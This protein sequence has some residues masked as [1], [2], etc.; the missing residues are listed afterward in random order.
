MY[1]LG[2]EHR[3]PEQELDLRGYRDSRPVRIGN[4]AV[5][6]FQLDIYGELMDSAHLYRRLGNE[7]D[8]EYWELLRGVVEFVIEHWREPDDGIWESR[9]ER[10]H[11]VFS[12]AMAWVA[13]D[14]AIQAVEETDLPGDLER[15]RTVRDAIRA[16]VLDHGYNAER[17]AFTQHYGGN[18]LD[19]SVLMLPLFRFIEATD[20]RMRST[21]DA[22]R[23]DLTSHQGFVYRYRDFDDGV[24]GTEGT[25]AICTFWLCNNLIQVGEVEEATELFRRAC[26]TAN[27]LGLMSEE[28]DPEDGMLGNFPQAFSHLALINVAVQLRRAAEANEENEAADEERNAAAGGPA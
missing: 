2:G 11:F 24:V 1:G 9:G 25:F 16:D 28:F 27:D 6:Q 5:G 15:W 26:A 4:G 13:L 7:I 8:P 10:R 14:R 3:L 19:A 17:G 12:K 18:G 22:I 20:P 23:R 21:I